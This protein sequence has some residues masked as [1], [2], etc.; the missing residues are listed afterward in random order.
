M[1]SDRPYRRALPLDVALGELERG[2]GTQFD[3]ELVDH[4]LQ[5]RIFE[6]V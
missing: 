2:R 5:H 3:P 6:V 1:T 4:F